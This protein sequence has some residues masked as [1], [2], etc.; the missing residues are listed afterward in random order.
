ME[1]SSIWRGGGQG[2]DLERAK[3]QYSATMTSCSDKHP[4]NRYTYKHRALE[5]DCCKALECES[6]VGGALL[7]GLSEIE[8][9]HAS[10]RRGGPVVISEAPNF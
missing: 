6:E 7:Q 1:A 2:D 8:P 4:D 10:D 3:L 5:R 9:R